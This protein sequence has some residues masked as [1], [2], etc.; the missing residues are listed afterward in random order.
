MRCRICTALLAVL[1]IGLPAWAGPDAD[2]GK[3]KK[4]N[5]ELRSRLEQLEGTVQ[6]LK[7]LVKDQS[8]QLKDVRNGKPGISRGDWLKLHK[9]MMR[10]AAGRTEGYPIWSNL[11]MQLYGYVKLDAAYN[12]SRV[13]H[14]NL[15]LFAN[16][17]GGRSNDNQ[18]NMTANQ[19]R[20]GVKFMGP[21][22]AGGKTSGR[23][24][25]DFYGGGAD[26]KANPR[27][28]MALFRIDWADQGLTFLAG[29]DNDVVAPLNPFTLDFGV[30]GWAGNIGFRRAQIR[31]TKC[32]DLGKDSTLSGTV[33]LARNI[34]DGSD[35]GPGD[36]GEDYGMPHLQ[37]RVAATFPLINKLKSTVGISG[38]WGREEL[39]TDAM[40]NHELYDTW[41]VVLDAYVPITDWLSVKGEAFTGR[42]LDAYLGGIG[43][44]VNTT[45]DREVDSC[46][47]WG[48][49]SLG[50][51]DKWRFN[52]GAGVDTVDKGDV[53]AGART[54]NRVIFGN[55]IYSLSENAS[56]G[57]E[58]SH[59]HTE[60]KGLDN[61]DS[62]RFQS[63]F[64]YKF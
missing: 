6:D 25:L 52:I 8:V 7:G 54:T 55:A 23:V 21:E 46:G 49:V 13:T 56:W 14:G 32:W 34:G 50:P 35:F 53:N 39:D 40:D 38:H 48:A 30:L 29:Q 63:S 62:L 9:E 33:A 28:R 57:F 27:I 41:S 24:E 47:G 61:G 18:F 5:E 51:W 2:V 45:L 42:N 3:L 4:E 19:T 16:S 12:T 36:S 10:D 44:G 15:T 37:Y 64:I 58:M 20:L 22:I 31:L 60:F 26:N 17:E 43:Q 1:A 59:W 11:K